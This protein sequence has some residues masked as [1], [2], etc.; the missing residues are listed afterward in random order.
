[1]TDTIVHTSS[2]HKTVSQ[3]PC[4]KRKW[5]IKLSSMHWISFTTHQFDFEINSFCP[6]E[7]SPISFCEISVFSDVMKWCCKPIYGIVCILLI[8][9]L[10]LQMPTL[11]QFSKFGVLAHDLPLRH[12][13]FQLILNT[14]ISKLIILSTLFLFM[15]ARVNSLRKKKNFLSPKTKENVEEWIICKTNMFSKSYNFYENNHFLSKEEEKKLI[16]VFFWGKLYHTHFIPSC[17]RKN[18]IVVFIFFLKQP[19]CSI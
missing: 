17:L 16:Y 6:S 19:W 1:M 13:I 9:F 18:Q 2:T 11:Y 5:S 10:A 8:N 4:S 15:R 14:L 7:G 3:C 12:T